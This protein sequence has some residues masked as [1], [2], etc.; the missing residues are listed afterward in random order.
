M[1]VAF[2]VG[3]HFHLAHAAVGIHAHRIGDAL[4]LADHFVDHDKTL[5]CAALPGQA[6]LQARRLGLD[7]GSCQ[8]LGQRGIERQIAQLESVGLR[9]HELLCL[10]GAH[11]IHGQRAGGRQRHHGRRGIQGD[12]HGRRHQKLQPRPR[13]TRLA[14]L[15]TRKRW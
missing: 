15:L 11:V 2:A 10:L 13:F 7:A 9:E 4:E 14:S 5:R 8:L 6:H 12:V 1:A 3:Q